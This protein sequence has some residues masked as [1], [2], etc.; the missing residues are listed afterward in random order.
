MMTMQ[1]QQRLSRRAMM[2]TAPYLA[3]LVLIA[4]SG[5]LEQAFHLWDRID[6][7][8]SATG[9]EMTGL[10]TALLLPFLLG[11]VLF[12]YGMHRFRTAGYPVAGRGDMEGLD[13]RQ[14]LRFLEAQAKTQ[15]FYLVL[16]S[17]FTFW[18]IYTGRQGFSWFFGVQ[19][20]SFV[21]ALVS[22]WPTVMLIQDEPDLEDDL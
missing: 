6:R 18:M 10:V 5:L 16:A 1:K 22:G 3:G 21:C 19:A 17:I 8:S 7:A 13:E 2:L 20:G 4:A 11:T 14:R 9:P 12:F 15:R